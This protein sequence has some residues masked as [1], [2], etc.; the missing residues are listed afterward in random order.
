MNEIIK[1]IKEKMKKKAIITNAISAAFLIAGIA[2]IALTFSQKLHILLAFAG[3]ISAILSVADILLTRS[4]VSRTI[5][6][7]YRYTPSIRKGTVK[8]IKEDHTYIVI[9]DNSDKQIEI[10]TDI[11]PE[12]V[13]AGSTINYIAYYEIVGTVRYIKY[14]MILNGKLC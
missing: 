8:E 3:A 12:G 2:A 9:P 10:R 14:A 5:A 1:Q 7:L 4:T 6:E 13:S 11:I